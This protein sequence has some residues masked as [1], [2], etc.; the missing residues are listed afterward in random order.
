MFAMLLFSYIISRLNSRLVQTLLSDWTA[1]HQLDT[2][3]EMFMIVPRPPPPTP[4]PLS[5][6]HPSSGPGWALTNV[7]K[8]WLRSG[9]GLGGRRTVLVRAILPFL[10]PGPLDWPRAE[11][12]RPAISSCCVCAFRNRKGA[13]LILVR[14]QRDDRALNPGSLPET[15]V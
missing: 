4:P 12:P 11:H 13:G 3:R 10:C 8:R 2:G 14:T 5:S 6:K 7:G 9:S 15:T 1:P